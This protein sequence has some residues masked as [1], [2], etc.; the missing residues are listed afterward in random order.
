VIGAKL[1]FGAGRHWPIRLFACIVLLNCFAGAALLLWPK[2]RVM[3]LVSEQG[4]SQREHFFS[5]V[6]PTGI[7]I[8]RRL[9]NAP[10]LRL[11]ESWSPQTLAMRGSIV[12]DPFNPHP[13]LA[14]PFFGFPG[15]LAGN[16]ILLRCLP[17]QA[18]LQVAN[19]RTNTQWG[20]AYLHVPDSFCPGQIRL[21]AHAASDH[22][23]V[24][25]GT[26]FKIS[27]AAYYAAKGFPVRGLALTLVWAWFCAL[28]TLCGVAV[29]APPREDRAMIAGYAGMGLLG[30]TAFFVY[31]FSPLTGKLLTSLLATSVPL[32]V[33]LLWRC[34]PALLRLHF[35][36][37]AVPFGLW[38]VVAWVYIALVSAIDNGGSSWAINAAFS[39]LRWSSDNQLPT[40]FAEAMFDGTP[41]DQIMWGDWLAADRPPLLSG[42]MLLVRA[43]LIGPFAAAVNSEFVGPSYMIAGIVLLTSWVPP[44]W[45]FGA[46]VNP[47][48]GGYLVVIA[49]MSPFFLFNSVYIWPKLL[50][51]TYALLVLL[52]LAS[53]V[54]G[55]RDQGGVILAGLCAALSILCHAS[56]ALIFPALAL[57]FATSIVRQGVV[58]L[59]LGGLAAVVTLIPWQLWQSF[60]QP[61]GNALIRYALTLDFGMRDRTKPI[62]PEIIATYRTLGLQGWIAS[63]IDG[64]MVIGGSMRAPVPLHE[65]ATYGPG[66]DAVGRLRIADFFSLTRGIL[67]PVVGL[68]LAPI[69]W[70]WHRPQGTG[71][72]VRTAIGGSL[73][74]LLTMLIFLPV[75]ITHVLPY[76]SPVFLLL[77]GASFLFAWP[78]LRGIA[79]LAEAVY[80]GVVWVAH[81]LVSALRLEALAL[82][83]LAAGLLLLFYVAGSSIDRRRATSVPDI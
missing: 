41:R 45:R 31:H 63:K 14:I 75:P 58:T 12:S 29:G 23:Y 25:V 21:E 59:A 27:A 42:L 81:P 36:T 39:P 18:V 52:S 2:G 71:L 65:A 61:H 32:A 80:F 19:I 1:G 33:A 74:V 30:L 50:G 34:R 17:N 56:N 15:E 38:F 20:T 6:L 44:V 16:T 54:P 46:R 69:L 79:L 67:I 26:P 78:V 73:G 9:L 51:A 70:T 40:L 37:M 28:I 57:V 35:E 55:R 64:V 5:G 48:G 24:G 68:M 83:A 77:A 66:V 76:A 4:W 47:H 8:P 13:Y 7:E 62:L 82:P 10:A 11:W 22:D 72:A 3:A 60:V 49:A 53:L 43:P